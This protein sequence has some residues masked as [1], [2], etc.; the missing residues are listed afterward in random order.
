MTRANTQD[1]SSASP[2]I[3]LSFVFQPGAVVAF[4]LVA[5]GA[6]GALL[7]RQMPKG[8]P[9]S[10]SAQ[11]HI[12]MVGAQKCRGFIHTQILSLRWRY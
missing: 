10:T 9:A 6:F 3:F 8:V 7:S 11:H 1:G 12:S 4:T 5:L 2:F